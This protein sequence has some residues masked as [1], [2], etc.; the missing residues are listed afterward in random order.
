MATT[1]RAV[2]TLEINCKSNWNDETTVSQVKK[3]AIDDAMGELNK[4]AHAS[5]NRI[6]VIGEPQIR[7][8]TFDAS[9]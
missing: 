9:T 2:V 6:K 8:V 1:A 4:I 3:Q 7:I 5:N